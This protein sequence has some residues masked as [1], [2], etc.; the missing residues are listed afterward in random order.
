M[1]KINLFVLILVVSVLSC[2]KEKSSA[3]CEKS[4]AT[5][6]GSYK[7]LAMTYKTNS[8]AAEQD[9]FATLE[10]CEK[11]DI[12]VLSAN[13]DADYRDAGVTCTP[14]GNYNSD[15]STNGN[16]ITMDGTVGTIKMFDCKKLVVTTTGAI[17]PGDIVTITYEKQ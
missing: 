15:W 2:K 3:S 14:N 13:G 5:I 11:D 17:I 1:E 10:T 12:V 7:T 6:A 4:M 16:N 8:A 9:I